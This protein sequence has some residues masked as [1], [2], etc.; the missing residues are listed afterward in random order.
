MSDDEQAFLDDL[1]TLVESYA[2]GGSPAT[3]ITEVVVLCRRHAAVLPDLPNAAIA[4]AILTAGRRET[5]GADP[6]ADPEEEA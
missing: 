2:P 1:S 6:D 4:E 5:E 3:L